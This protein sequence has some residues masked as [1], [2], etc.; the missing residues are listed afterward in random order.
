M[1]WLA[2]VN[3]NDEEIGKMT[4]DKVYTILPIHRIVHIFI[5]NEKEE[6]LL[7]L[8]SDKKS[9]CPLHWSTSAGGHVRYGETYEMAALR[10]IKEE[11]GI[12]IEIV[13]S[14]KDYYTDERGIKRFLSTFSGVYNGELSIN[15]NEVNYV[16]FFNIDTIRQM[17]KSGDKFHPELL[18]LLKKHYDIS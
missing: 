11:L 7:Q 6:M 1:E 14:H 13:F 15:N 12:E 18:F 9:F 4:Y 10:E 5:L 16:K 8:R 17:I 3:E 2:V